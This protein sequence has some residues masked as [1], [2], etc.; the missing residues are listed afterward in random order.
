MRVVS[1]YSGRTRYQ[2]SRNETGHKTRLLLQGKP[3]DPKKMPGLNLMALTG[4]LCG[5]VNIHKAE[6]NGDEYAGEDA[7]FGDP[8]EVALFQMAVE[9]G[10]SP[11]SI[12]KEYQRI[13]E[14][15]FDSNRKMMTVLC[16]LRSGE[17]IILSKG[18]PEIILQKCT[19]VMV[20]NNV[21]RILDYDIQRIEKEN[22]YMAQN[23]LRVIA[24]AYR[25]IEREKIYP[26]I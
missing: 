12:I 15:P 8:T 26:M 17:K 23:A 10:Y 7:F 6:N 2:V 16:S 24:M 4:I 11:E 22:T 9:A 18:A 14:I 1:I 25:V 21:R 13:K 3:V 5:N 19:S 20:A